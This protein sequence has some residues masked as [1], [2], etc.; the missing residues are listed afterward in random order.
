MKIILKKPRNITQRQISKRML[1][2]LRLLAAQV[3]LIRTDVRLFN[4]QN[5][6][7]QRTKMQIAVAEFANIWNEK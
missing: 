6:I 4:V 1:S 3:F 2:M 7:G 5:Q